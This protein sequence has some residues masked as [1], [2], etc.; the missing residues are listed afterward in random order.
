MFLFLLLFFFAR[1]KNLK[2]NIRFFFFFFL[3]NPNSNWFVLSFSLESKQKKKSF[4]FHYPSPS[5]SLLPAF[6]IFCFN[7]TKS[8]KVGHFFFQEIITNVVKLN[9]GNVLFLFFF[10]KVYNFSE[11]THIYIHIN[12]VISKFIHI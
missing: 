6:P 5:F 11:Y 8:S 7:L 2:T 10:F 4:F 12:Q 3:F 1:N 9:L